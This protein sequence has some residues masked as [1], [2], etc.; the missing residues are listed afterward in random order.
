MK[1]KKQGKKSIAAQYKCNQN[2]IINKSTHYQGGT[3]NIIAMS[4]LLIA[5]LNRNL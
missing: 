1:H 4:T 3:S 5:L 2:L